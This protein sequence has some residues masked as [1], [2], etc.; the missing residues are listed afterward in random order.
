MQTEKEYLSERSLI[1]LHSES[2][3]EYT[4]PDYNGDVKRVLVINPRL[5]PGGKFINESSVEFSGVI[6][7]EVV[8]LDSE[9][10]IA[11]AKFSTDYEIAVKTDPDVYEDSHVKTSLCGYNVRLLGPR[12]FS[13]KA[14]LE[15]DVR[16]LE[17]KSVSIDGDAFEENEPEILRVGAQVMKSVIAVG[18]E[19][20]HKEELL[21]LDGAIED[22]ISVLL[23]DASYKMVS[24]NPD[25]SGADIKAEIALRLLYKNAEDEI[26]LKN[27][28]L[29]YS[30]R[31]DSSELCDC[32]SLIC[33][34][35]TTSINTEILP[36]E[37]GVTI[38]CTLCTLPSVRG[39]RNESLDLVKDAY[40]KEFG[41]INEYRDF[42]Y[43]EH[44]CTQSEERN[45][46]AK[47]PL[48]DI[49]EN[50]ICDVIYANSIACVNECELVDFG[51]KV[52]GE[53]R[54]SAIVREENDGEQ[55]YV[56]A[57][58]VVPF[59][60][61][62]NINCQKHDNMRVECSAVSLDDKIVS[63]ENGVLASAALL[64]TVTLNSN[65]RQRCLGACSLTDE[66]YEKEKSVVIAYY[67]DSS[68]SIFEIAKRFRTSPLKIAE[69][70]ALSESA[71]AAK[72]APVSSFG[73]KK[74]LI[75]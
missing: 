54:F 17:S 35:E 65:K 36:N 45:I 37:S 41:T 27:V 23:C 14:S 9:N 74:L 55:N 38:N 61:N 2:A 18:N 75:K 50:E 60:E 10:N 20:E 51:V 43:T 57:R 63:T 44:I 28:N 58:F 49:C 12:K 47:I 15:S 71:F 33:N 73:Y 59:E 4:L 13:A 11:C 62:V 25:E 16:I 24:V 67:P 52:K 8:Y 29:P 34:I 39:L 42:D 48:T 64:I 72:D 68:E 66:R 40:L 31:V 32:G 7:Y 5:S 19:S 53:V 70:N 3:G 21:A 46:S 30:A 69:D 6:S 22:E 56:N 26:T 1:G